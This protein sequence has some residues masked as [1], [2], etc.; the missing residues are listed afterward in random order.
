MKKTTT[1]LALL[2]LAF[3]FYTCSS[4]TEEALEEITPVKLSADLTAWP[5]L[6][7]YHFF[8]GDIKNLDPAFG[9]LPY[10][11]ASELFTD[12]ALKKDLFGCLKVPKQLMMAMVIF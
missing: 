7:D 6:S 3:T 1:Y 5:K 9:V 2:L 10:K 8:K 12:Y 11:P 4:D